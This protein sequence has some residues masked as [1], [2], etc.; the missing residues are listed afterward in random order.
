MKINWYKVYYAWLIIITIT[1]LINNEFFRKWFLMFLL[2]SIVCG[3]LKAI[4]D[5]QY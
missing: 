2:G 3:V 5:R 4:D 1:S